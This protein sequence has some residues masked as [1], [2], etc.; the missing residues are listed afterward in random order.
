MMKKMNTFTDFIACA[1]QLVRNKYTSS[2]RLVIHGGSAGGLLMG[3]VANMRPDLFKAVVAQVPFVD[4][5]TTMLDA[6]LPLTTNEYT[7]W[8]N[9]NDKAAYDYIAKYSPYDNVR[10]QAYPAMLVRVSV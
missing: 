7:E 10:A 2:D 8:G 9:P 5:L 3:A 4:V 1:E 6:S